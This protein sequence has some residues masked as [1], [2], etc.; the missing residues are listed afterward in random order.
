M[1]TFVGEVPAEFYVEVIIR[2]LFIY[3]L[4]I[5]A[6]RFMGR[7]MAAQLSRNEMLSLMVLAAAIG[8]PLQSP[9]RGLLPAL[10]IAVVVVLIGRL[11]SA[12]FVSNQRLEKKFQG[13]IDALVEDGVMKL[14]VMKEVRITIDRLCAH[15]RSEGVTHLGEVKRLYIEANGSFTLVREPHPQPGLSVLPAWDKDF[16]SEQETSDSV[17]V[18]SNCG[19]K[20]DIKQPD[21]LCTNCGNTRWKK[22][23]E[24][25]PGEEM[26]EM[27]RWR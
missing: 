21:R 24:M 3:V 14:D 22:A 8:V 10:L 12:L 17:L 19:G 5:A 11:L 25:K 1:R 4:L 6:M 27:E 9:D 26:A 23:V 2:T 15:V 20:R 7:R 13:N 18:C 16:L